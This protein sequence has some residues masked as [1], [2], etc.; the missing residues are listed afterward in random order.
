LSV[1]RSTGATHL[2]YALR[3]ILSTPDDPIA[4]EQTGAVSMQANQRRGSGYR[5]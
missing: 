5:A 1:I 3:G 4:C 2:S